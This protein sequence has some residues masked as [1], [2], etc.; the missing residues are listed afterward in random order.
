M[1]VRSVLKQY[2]VLFLARSA[3]LGTE[4]NGLGRQANSMRSRRRVLSPRPKIP[5]LTVWLELEFFML[6]TFT[7]K[8][9]QSDDNHQFRMVFNIDF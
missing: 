2:G 5:I 1:K 8:P 3:Q 6:F 7:K 4:G 9:P